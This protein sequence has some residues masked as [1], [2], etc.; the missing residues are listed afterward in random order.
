MF[1][2]VASVITTGPIQHDL[3]QSALKGRLVLQKEATNIFTYLFICLFV[4]LFVFC[5]FVCLFVYLFIYLFI[6]VFMYLFI[7]LFIKRYT[8]VGTDLLHQS[9]STGWNEI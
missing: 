7:Y 5:L 9:W 6:Y 4:C 3:W 2:F 8:G 1:A